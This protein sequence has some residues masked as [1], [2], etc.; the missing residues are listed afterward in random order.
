MD[1]L[2]KTG[3]M[4]PMKI[5]ITEKENLR[6]F[7]G[8][9]LFNLGFRPFFLGA[10]VVGVL[11]MFAWWGQY[12]G[13]IGSADLTPAWH[14]HEMLFGYTL[15]VIAGFLLTSVRNWT[16]LDTVSGARLFALFC[17]WVV[18]R[19]ANALGY[20]EIAAVSDLVF[21]LWFGWCA[22]VPIIKVKQWRQT[23][24]VGIIITLA[25]ANGLY[26]AGQLSLVTNGIYFGNYIGFYVVVGLILVMTG[27]VVPFFIE[28]GVEEEVQLPSNPRLEFFIFI[29][30]V[31]FVVANLVQPAMS[32]AN[33]FVYGLAALLFVLNCIRLMSW[34]AKG[35][36][37][38]PLLWTLFVAYGF[39][40]L[41]F[42]LY[43]LLFFGW[44]NIFIPIHSIA[45]GGVGL[46]TLSMM[47]RVTLGHSGRS[48]H[49]PPGLMT[50]AF[51][52][53]L[54]ATVLRVFFP[55]LLPGFHVLWIQASQLLWI[56]AFALF[57]VAYS[58]MLTQP[59]IDN[60]PG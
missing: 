26:Y 20:I 24:I 56:T 36:W 2:R 4:P 21:M 12:S 22:V 49:E 6:K 43:A 46:L 37:Q 41:G 47:A 14:A 29:A 35:I 10:G 48:I 44:F 9:A 39:I 34:Y 30:Y 18:A 50:F 27:R 57:L 60:R 16:G 53:L 13:Y 31:A 3:R 19:V 38:K 45:V 17:F 15:A 23:A 40:V 54:A 25:L 7:A 51:A 1:L 5:S 28:R 11:A 33:N 55:L 32:I 52:A 58:P 8:T 59:R 42:L